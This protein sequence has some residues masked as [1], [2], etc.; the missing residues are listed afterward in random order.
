MKK[1]RKL[2][3]KI[4][5]FFAIFC[6]LMTLVTIVF[7]TYWQMDNGTEDPIFA[8][9]LASIFFFASCGFVLQ[10]IANANLPDLK[11]SN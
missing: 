4:S 5:W 9:A 6:Y 7:A 2:G 10:Y 11:I 3:Q 8:S 1:K